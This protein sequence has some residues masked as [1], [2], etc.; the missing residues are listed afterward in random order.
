MTDV[1]VKDYGYSFI[2]QL[3]DV[4]AFIVC[5][6]CETHIVCSVADGMGTYYNNWQVLLP[7]SRSDIARDDVMISLVN[8]NVIGWCCGRC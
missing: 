1:I 4:I 3:A 6:R 7:H 2:A 8:V 5:G